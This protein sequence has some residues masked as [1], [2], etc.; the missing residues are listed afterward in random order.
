MVRVAGLGARS[1]CAA[2][3]VPPPCR[4]S[5]TRRVT[6]D[7]ERA[8]ATP[9]LSAAAWPRETVSFAM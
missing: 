5:V 9:S 7:A 6:D 8:R 3:S 1:W 2:G 4:I